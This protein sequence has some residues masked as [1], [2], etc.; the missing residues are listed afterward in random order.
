M[1]QS[2]TGAKELDRARAAY[3]SAQRTLD[4]IETEALNAADSELAGHLDPLV[5]ERRTLE[6]SQGLYASTAGRR[7][8]CDAVRLAPKNLRGIDFGEVWKAMGR[9]PDDWAVAPAPKGAGEPTARQR[10]WWEFA[11]GSKLVVD[12]PR[13]LGRVHKTADLPHAEL[14][15]PKGERLDQEGIEVPEGSTPAHMTITDH[16]KRLRDFFA[17]RRTGP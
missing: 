16:A 1:K 7:I 11:D 14:H 10:L 8:P 3:E 4:Q 17:E 5:K 13:E 2:A 12:L 15:G 6:T 9:P